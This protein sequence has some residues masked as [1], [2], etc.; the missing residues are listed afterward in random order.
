VECA[1]PAGSIYLCGLEQLESLLKQFPDVSELAELDPIDSPLIVSP[2]ELAEV[3]QAF[4]RQKDSVRTVLDHPPTDRVKY[5]H[6]NELNNM[7]AD[8]AKDQIKRYLKETTQIHAFL[9]A[10]ENLEL[11]QAY[12]S[13]VDEFQQK[14]IAY[15][16]DHQT[17]DK[18][19]E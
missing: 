5:E 13:V 6:K 15:R 12:E 8:Y 10:P 3:V 19:L 4:A 16:K 11:L 18:V 2:D 7:T 17:F 14:I 1:I 9:A